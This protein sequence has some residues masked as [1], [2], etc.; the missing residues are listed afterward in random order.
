MDLERASREELVEIIRGLLA[1]LEGLEARVAELEAENLRLRRG[2]GSPTEFSIKPSRPPKE[3]KARKHRAQAFVR[4]REK[5]DEVR[6][7]ALERCP[8]CG[9][10]LTGAGREHRRHQVIELELRRRVV[11]HVVLARRCGVCGKRALPKLEDKETGAVGQRR[12]GASI[13]SLVTVLH[14]A[15]RLPIRKIRQMRRETAGLHLSRGSVVKLLP[16]R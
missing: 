3:K 4:R 16:L 2:G 14:V 10:K 7:H 9:A 13:Q 1:R 12:F 5:A 15:G 8:D 11:D 6:Y